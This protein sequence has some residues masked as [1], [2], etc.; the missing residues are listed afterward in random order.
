MPTFGFQTREPV[1]VELVRNL[2]ED[3]SPHGAGTSSSQWD[4]RPDTWRSSIGKAA[5]ATLTL[6]QR[7][8]SPLCLIRTICD[9]VEGANHQAASDGT[10]FRRRR[11]GRGLI[12]KLDQPSSRN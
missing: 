7:N 9:I 10:S 4:A 1:G 2:M 6:V 12:D 5:G 11:A 3:A 8:S